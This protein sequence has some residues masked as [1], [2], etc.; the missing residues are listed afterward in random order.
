MNL[1]K[2]LMVL[3]CACLLGL[4]MLAGAEE[5]VP[6]TE[7]DAITISKKLRYTEDEIKKAILAA[8]KQNG[9]QVMRDTP[10]VMQLK[11]QGQN[12]G[13]ELVMDVNYNARKYKLKYSGSVG[14]QYKTE[15]S[16]VIAGNNENANFVSKNY[17]SGPSI[18]RKYDEWVKQL[19]RSI[20]RQLR[21]GDF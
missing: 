4:P 12:D 1:L 17:S 8:A 15:S 19:T 11:I 21:S 9:W 16:P 10:G 20:K 7:P 6:F 18:S 2:N 3:M 5:M 13:T 14:L